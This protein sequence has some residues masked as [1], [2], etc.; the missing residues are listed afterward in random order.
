MTT[1]RL[2]LSFDP[3]TVDLVRAR[4]REVGKPVS[5]YLAD[6]VAADPQSALDQLA[7]EGYRELATDA[8]AFAYASIPLARE[9]WSE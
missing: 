8:T 3:Q 5:R 9:S 4:A 1:V 6:L 2:N 7:A